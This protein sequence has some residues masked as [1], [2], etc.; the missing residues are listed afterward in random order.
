MK[1][2][3]VH[4]SIGQHCIEQGLRAKLKATSNEFELWDSD[5]NRKGT[6]D[7]NG[8]LVEIPNLLVPD[9]NTNPDG[10]EKFVTSVFFGKNIASMFDILMVKSCFTGARIRSSKMLEK[11]MVAAR[12][13]IDLVKNQRF[14][15]VILTPVPD[16]RFFSSKTTAAR[17]VS[18]ADYV[19]TLCEG[20][21]TLEVVNLHRLLGDSGGYLRGPLRTFWG[22]DPHPNPAGIELLSTAICNSVQNITVRNPLA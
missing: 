22:L 9:D 5:Y 12:G 18:Y 17:A 2:L 7:K 13:M 15:T 21:K 10:L 19:S 8:D 20:A 1:I 4:H 14:P 6:H 3:F 11:Y 16:T